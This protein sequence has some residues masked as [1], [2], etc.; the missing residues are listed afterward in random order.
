MAESRN[1]FLMLL[2][3]ILLSSDF[4][5]AIICISCPT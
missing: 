3:F 1:R 5:I 2:L 4:Q